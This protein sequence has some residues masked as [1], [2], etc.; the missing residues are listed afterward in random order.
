MN[1]SELLTIG[2]VVH[3]GCLRGR[4]A[5]LDARRKLSAEG[6][7]TSAASRSHVSGVPGHASAATHSTS[8]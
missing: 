3:V 2:R 4:V 1:A 5:W 6:L 8:N 7:R